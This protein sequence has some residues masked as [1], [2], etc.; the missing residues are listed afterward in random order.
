MSK[1]SN[2]KKKHALLIAAFILFTL[3]STV[4]I[5]LMAAV[6]CIV[7]MGYCIYLLKVLD[8]NVHNS[9][10]SKIYSE[11][12]AHVEDLQ[13]AVEDTSSRIK[14][15]ENALGNHFF[16]NSKTSVSDL[17]AV[18]KIISAV[19]LRRDEIIKLINVNKNKNL[20]DARQ[21]IRQE[22]IVKEDIM[23]SVIDAREIPPIN[24][25]ILKSF[26]AEVLT[27]IECDLEVGKTAAMR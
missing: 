26:L 2:Y 15:C 20:V 27:R 3:G 6:L 16:E 4:D 14:K 25:S 19:K 8:K 17:A 13:K 23:N 1:K 10:S 21:L 5:L 18:R 11:I 9:N 12:Y 22:I 24:P 7:A